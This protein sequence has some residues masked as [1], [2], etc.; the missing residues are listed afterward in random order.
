MLM[1]PVALESV[2]SHCTT[3]NVTEEPARSF[4]H[5]M[6]MALSA[7]SPEA[8]AP[9]PATGPSADMGGLFSM[10]SMGAPPPG[11]L[12]CVPDDGADRIFFQC[13]FRNSGDVLQ[14]ATASVRPRTS[15]QRPAAPCTELVHWCRV[16][17]YNVCCM[18]VRA[19]VRIR[20]LRVCRRMQALATACEDGSGVAACVG[21]RDADLLTDACL[22]AAMDIM[23]PGA[24]VKNGISNAITE[25]KS[26]CGA[27]ATSVR[28]SFPARMSD[29][30]KQQASCLAPAAR[31][32]CCRRLRSIIRAPL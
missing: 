27:A 28:S 24:A 8:T 15:L 20:V 2:L 3:A 13:A 32:A 17:V 10:D 4:Y 21:S 25:S 18:P 5:A 1:N 16:H 19:G 29:Q 22:S 12:A 26:L 14:S 6:A 23:E 9:G 7:S 30:F 31:A 11:V